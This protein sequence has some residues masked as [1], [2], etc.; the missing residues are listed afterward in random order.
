MSNGRNVRSYLSVRDA[1]RDSEEIRE[2]ALIAVQAKQAELRA[3]C[4]GGSLYVQGECGECDKTIAGAPLDAYSPEDQAFYRFWYGHMTD[5]LM[6]PP[7]AGISHATARYIWD[8]A[9]SAAH[10]VTGD[11]NA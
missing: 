11:R 8:A 9:R 10:G 5:D 4:E 6:Q 7:L 3:V 2:N 1:M